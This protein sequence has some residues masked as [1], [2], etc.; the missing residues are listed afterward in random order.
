M[1]TVMTTPEKE[2]LSQFHESEPFPRID[3]IYCS[4]IELLSVR[5]CSK[6]ITRVI[7]FSP[8]NNPMKWV[9]LSSFY[10]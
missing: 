9:L 1:D 6:C 2:R 7:S 10:K 3:A 4:Y 5:D 8:Y